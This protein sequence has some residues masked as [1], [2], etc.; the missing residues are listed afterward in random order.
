[1]TSSVASPQAQGV[2]V[3]R[4]VS[5]FAAVLCTASAAVVHFA[6]VPQHLH[7]Y[8]PF[9]I[10]FIVVGLLQIA[11]AVLMLVA[12]GRRLFVVG[13]GGTAVL[14]GLWLLSRTTG[15]PIGPEPGEA[16]AVGIPDVVCVAMEVLAILL[17]VWLALRR[18][19]TKARRPMRTALA[20]LPTLVLV[21]LLTYVGSGTGLAVMPDAANAAPAVPGQPSTSVTSLVAAPGSQ[22]VKDFTLTA[23]V[24]TISGRPVW[25]YNGTVPGPELR[26]NQGDR[27]RVTLVNHLPVA[28]TLHWHGVSVPNAEDGVAGVTQDAV[29]AGGSFRYEFVANDQGTYWYHSHQ[30]TAN[31]IIAGLFGTLIVEPPVGHVA[32]TRD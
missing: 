31:Q 10:F 6:V 9:G 17:L 22:P 30:D 1:M 25:T 32:E 4:S 21:A 13:A 15:L 12:P 16:E 28:T 29:P 7:E 19:S 18:P 24:R 23:E 2:A 5:L 14:V 3:S 27:V 8:L 11:L 26:V 20:T